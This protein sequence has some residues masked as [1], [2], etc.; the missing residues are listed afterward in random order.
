V[1]SSCGL[2]LSRR[3]LVAVAVDNGGR[4]APA[5]STS[6]D[7]ESRRALLQHLDALHGFDCELVLP[8]QLLKVDPIAQ[9]ALR[10]GLSVWIAPQPLVL[11]IRLAAGLATGPPARTAAMIARLALVPG[12]RA[13]LRRLDPVLDGRQLSLL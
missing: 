6:L 1:K 8:E 12:W 9:L 2:W 11:G 7:D 13:H 5:V 10:R 3:R 4:A